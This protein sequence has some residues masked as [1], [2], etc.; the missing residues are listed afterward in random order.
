MN[1]AATDDTSTAMQEIHTR[2]LQD[3]S[4][5]RRAEIARA[6]SSRAVKL[7]KQAIRRNNPSDSERMVNL[8]FIALAY[9]RALA[10]RVAQYLERNVG[11]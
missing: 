3:Q 4:P 2:V 8:R 1:R 7:S 9:G 5:A 6:L 10:D 11:R